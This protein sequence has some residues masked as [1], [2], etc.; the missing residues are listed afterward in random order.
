MTAPPS[1]RAGYHDYEDDD[2]Y[3]ELKRQILQLTADED[4]SQDYHEAK[5]SNAHIHV[6]QATNLSDTSRICEGTGVF[7]P[8]IAKSRRRN[9]PSNFVILF[10]Q[11]RIDQVL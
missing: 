7:I 8:Q 10:F 5:D 6:L 2:F 9:K 3:V 4:N 11:Y 1:P